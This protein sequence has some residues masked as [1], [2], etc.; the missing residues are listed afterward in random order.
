VA[1]DGNGDGIADSAQ[2]AVASAT[3]VQS[4]TGLS[5]PGTAPP[6]FLTLVSGSVEG[7]PANTATDAQ[8]TSLTQQDA[9]ADL[10]EGLEMPLGL[11]AFTAALASGVSTE[12]F[13]LYVDPDLGING[14]W[15]QDNSGTWAN[16]ASAPY[17]GET[18]MEGGR[19]R[20][21]F[22]IDDGGAFDQD[23]AVNGVISD[24][25]APAFMPLSLVGQAPD[26]PAQ[27]FFF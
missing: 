11:V 4:D 21:D 26:L 19:L 20:L 9:P 1:G 12:H 7:K 17:G 16:L 14:Y 18:V 13:S 24:P 23:G 25:G 6:T 8:I 5:N 3:F 10:P 2:P 27:G 22:K 15:K